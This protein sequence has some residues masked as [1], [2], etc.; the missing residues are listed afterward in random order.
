ME[1]SGATELR[2]IRHAPALNGGRLCGRTD[3][4]ADCSDQRIL[5]TVRR[6]VGTPNRLVISPAV[7]CRQTV[8]ALWGDC[9]HDLDH[10]LWEQDFGGWEGL[11]YADLPDLGPLSGDALAA[12]RPPGGE[13]FADVCERI[14]PALQEI[15]A[16]RDVT[17]VAHAGTVRAGLALAVGA[18]AALA[19]EIAPLSVTRLRALP[20]GGWSIAEVNWTAP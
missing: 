14:G 4:D 3:V 12:H 20:G 17:I 1:R 13:S 19:F 15:A 7:R 9:L 18:T 5:D 10:R 2:L 8:S 6:K 11:P 16:A